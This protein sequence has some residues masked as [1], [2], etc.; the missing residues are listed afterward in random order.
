MFFRV[1]FQIILLLSICACT[2]QPRQPA[3]VMELVTSKERKLKLHTVRQ[4]ET[5]YEIAWIYDY[6]YRDLATTNHLAYPYQIIPGQKLVIKKPSS[7]QKLA[8]ALQK[9]EPKIATKPADKSKKAEAWIL[10][11]KGRVLKAYSLKAS[12]LNKG[13]DIAGKL[14]SP[15]MAAQAGKVV[16][17]GSGLRGYGK[18][19]IIKHSDEYLS[20]YAHNNTLLVKEGDII[21]QG[22]IIAKMGYI[23]D[24]NVAL[25]FEIRKNGQPVNPL[26]FIKAV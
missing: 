13:I 1:V 18:L 24:K 4:G 11:A 8:T 23:D 12:T 15:V 5:L 16:Y 14:N 10:P 6:D 17:S 3:P 19:I 2:G 20:A 21:E 26:H 25:H 9:P 7:A 22:Q